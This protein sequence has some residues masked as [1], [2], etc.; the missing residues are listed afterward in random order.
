MAALL[1]PPM[2]VTEVNIGYLNNIMPFEELPKK[3][4]F[5]WY[6]KDLFHY[7]DKFMTRSLSE[8]N[9]WSLR[10][11]DAFT[12]SSKKMTNKTTVMFL[13]DFTVQWTTCVKMNKAEAKQDKSLEC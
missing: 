3:R 5:S 13:W 11:L 1:Y 10:C 7:V 6:A 12:A 4:N 2:L 8:Q 9:H